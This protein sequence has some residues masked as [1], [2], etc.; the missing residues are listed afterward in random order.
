MESWTEQNG[1]EGL[2]TLEPFYCSIFLS[3][4]KA[5]PRKQGCACMFHTPH[6]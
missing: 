1:V 5:E 3:K 4:N 2:L 6:D